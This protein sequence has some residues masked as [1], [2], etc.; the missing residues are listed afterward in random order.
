MIPQGVI[1]TLAQF[2]QVSFQPGEVAT[3]HKHDDMYEIFLV[4]SGSGVIKI[5]EQQYPLEKG[6]CVTVEPGEL[7]EVTNT[8]SEDLVL[9]YFGIEEK[10]Q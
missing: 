1:P 2:S 7:H 8:G 4:E 3:E 6:T 10:A 5:N 9:T